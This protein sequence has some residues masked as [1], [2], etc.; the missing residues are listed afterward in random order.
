MQ[1]DYETSLV[2]YETS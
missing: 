1:H 2:Y